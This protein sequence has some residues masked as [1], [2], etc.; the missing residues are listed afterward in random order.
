M[1]L[2]RRERAHPMLI[3]TLISVVLVMLVECVVF[4]APFW[5]T[6]SAS[7]DSD[8][9]DNTMGTGLVRT[10][11][12]LLKI[13]DPTQAYLDVSADGTS[14]YARVDMIAAHSI[15]RSQLHL[16]RSAVAVRLDSDGNVGQSQEISAQVQRSLFMRTDATSHIRLWIQEPVDSLIAIR[17]VRANVRIPF[18]CDWLRMAVMAGLLLLIALWRPG[19]GLWKI[20]LK[21]K[22]RWQRL[23]LVIS[24]SPV[25]IFTLVT[26]LGILRSSTPLS[27]HAPGGYTYDFDQYGHLADALIHGR[28][29]LDLPVP[30]A[31]AEA[32]N[33]YSTV[34]REQLLTQG[35]SPIYWDYAFYQGHWYSYFGILPALLLFVPYNLISRLWT[36]GGSM[37]PSSAAVLILIIG[38][39]IFGSLLVIRL[40]Q[41]LAPKASLAATSMAITVFMLGSNIGYLSQR[42][43]F[44]SI[45]FA[46]SLLFSTLGLWLWLG[47]EQA[48]RIRHGRWS[49]PG[50]PAISLPHLA[51]GTL[52]IA[53]NIG[54]RPTFSVVAFLG[55]AIFWKQITALSHGLFNAKHTE[56]RREQREEAQRKL[57]SV[58]L[59]VLLPAFA[60]VIPVV[61]YNV[62]RF[63][64]PFDFGTSYQLTVT[65][66]TQYS[67]PAGNIGTII[68]DYLLLPLHT[69]RHFPFLTV[70]SA[71]LSK[72][73]YSEPLVG[74]LLTLCPVLI[75]AILLPC[76]RKRLKA[77]RLWGMMVTCLILAAI[78]LTID[79]FAGGLGWRYMTDFGWLIAMP[80]IAVMLTGLSRTTEDTSLDTATGFQ[81][82]VRYDPHSGVTSDS[83][84]APHALRHRILTWLSRWAMLLLVL[85]SIVLAALSLFVSGRNDALQQTNPTMFYT[86]QSWFTMFR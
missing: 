6:L 19:S 62:A 10:G 34:A 75:L 40:V 80:T 14:S 84:V 72:W 24:L 16:L 38:F 26:I 57:I 42:T 65:D 25:I 35:V 59:A 58:S 44:Y 39:F 60:M 74:G 46:A 77:S 41:R 81:S 13:T 56:H 22:N 36:P 54:C 61:M 43:N 68:A 64:S 33:P 50:A 2:N 31:L 70:S 71:L 49:L 29:W 73:S 85:L 32:K 20:R 7:T 28:T 78:T 37:L 23:M 9:A 83:H 69:T 8:A 55:V 18:H 47:A 67:T 11:D 76:A 63:G 3:H 48:S 4:N 15:P 45:P 66:M 21:P 79:T 53:A 5:T 30:Q 17:A 1:K 27:F 51:G 52:C 86:V 12:G 82:A